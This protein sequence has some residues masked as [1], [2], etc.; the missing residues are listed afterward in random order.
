M[1]NIIKQVKKNNTV[2]IIMLLVVLVVIIFYSIKKREKFDFIGWARGAADTV[3]R[4]AE[5]VA[6][7]ISQDEKIKKALEIAKREAQNFGNKAKQFG[8]R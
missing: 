4:E 6:R 8:R 1:D 5:N 3:K 2:I 7:K